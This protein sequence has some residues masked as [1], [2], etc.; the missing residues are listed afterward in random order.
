MTVG[1]F[2]DH[3]GDDRRRG[4]TGAGKLRRCA[5]CR[6]TLRQPRRAAHRGYAGGL[7]IGTDGML[8][9]WRIRLLAGYSHSG[10]KANGRNSSA[11]SDNY[12]LGHYGGSQ[13]VKPA[14]G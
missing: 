10:F 13:S 5:A 1:Q 7:L 2:N 9:D 3:Y 14:R 4:S 11:S 8:G 6:R 12:H